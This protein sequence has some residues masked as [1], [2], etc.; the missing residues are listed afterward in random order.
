MPDKV[1]AVALDDGDTINYTVRGLSEDEIPAWAEFCASVFSYK[2]D[3]P[4][5][6]YFARHYANDPRRDAAMVRVACTEAGRIV[7]SCRVFQRTISAGN[8]ETVEAGGIGEVCTDT[9][10]RRRGL[11]KLLLTDAMDMMAD[12]GMQTSLLHSAPAFF[13]VYGGVGYTCTTSK[14][15]VVSVNKRLLASSDN[16]RMAAFPKD[17]AR[18]MKVHQDYSE[19]RFLG[20][21]VRSEQYWNEYLAKELEGTIYVVIEKGVIAG[22]MSLRPRSGRYQIRDFGCDRTLV[23]TSQ[24]LSVLLSTAMACVEADVVEIQLPTAVVN[25]VR[26]TPD[27]SY[28]NWSMVMNENDLGWMYKT[29]R[30]GAADIPGAVDGEHSH[31]IWPA[32]TF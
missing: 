18:L 9:D 19:K 22:W 32:D 1:V 31:L 5:P 17:T 12:R 30:D 26:A 29:L 27:A 20:T 23:D 15:S 13:P 25:E 7:S 3:P 16:V 28:I 2:E 10:H 21:I 14:W 6:C 24:A 11:S 4:P 8:G